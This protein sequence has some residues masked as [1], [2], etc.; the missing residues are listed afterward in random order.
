M[1]QKPTKIYLVI[2][3]L[4]LAIL[5]PVIHILIAVQEAAAEAL[6]TSWGWR[7][8]DKEAEQMLL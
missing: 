2:T 4:F 6:F 1:L 7:L 8:S 5:I 3:C